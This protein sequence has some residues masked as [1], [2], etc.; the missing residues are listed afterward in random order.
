MVITPFSFFD[1]RP[2]VVMGNMGHRPERGLRTPF[3][4]YSL[5]AKRTKKRRNAGKFD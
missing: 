5:N 2:N 3:I 4:L 1:P